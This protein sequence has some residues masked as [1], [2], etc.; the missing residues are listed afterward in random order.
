VSD[1]TNDAAADAEAPA[2]SP[3]TILWIAAAVGVVVVALIGVLALSPTTDERG[4][5]SEL[6][7]KPVPALQG[8]T[9]DGEAFDIDDLR[10]RWV[11]VNF[12]AVWCT[13]CVVEHPE[14]VE[15][16]ERHA[17]AGDAVIVS[18]PFQ[19]TPERVARF[20]DENGGEWP[21]L[22]GD[23]GRFPLDFGVAGVPESYLVSPDG[24]VVMKAYGVE[25]DQLDAVIDS[26]SGRGPAEG[27]P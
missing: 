19:E 8:T 1:V 3:R 4:I 26:L 14:L 13:P 7:D 2:R 24:I 25:A 10:G 27:Q 18:V 17:E 15:F 6:I 11:L 9:M 20:F 5:T 21:V 12:F 23:V 22:A 16:A